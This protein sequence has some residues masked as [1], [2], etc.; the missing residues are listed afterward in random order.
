MSSVVLVADDDD[1]LRATAAE[2]LSVTGYEVLE[3]RD[4]AEA[5]HI[6]EERRVDVLLLDVRMP[7]RDGYSVLDVLGPPPPVVVLESAYE[8]TNEDRERVGSKVFK[9]LRKP[10]PPRSLIKAVSEATDNPG[11]LGGFSPSKR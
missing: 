1:N 9:Y 2:I 8:F 4:G 5:L 6:L 11:F 3:A 10:V 7:N